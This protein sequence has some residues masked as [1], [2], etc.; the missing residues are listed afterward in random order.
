MANG[1]G[2]GRDLK[3]ARVFLVDQNSFFRHGLRSAL[4]RRQ[5]VEVV[6]DAAVEEGVYEIIRSLLPEVVLLGLGSSVIPG[7]QLTRK[8]IQS[9]PGTS[10]V[11]VTSRPDDDELL[12][13][14]A[15][16]AAAYSSKDIEADDLARIIV[17]VAGGELPVIE[18]LEDNPQLLARTIGHFQDLLLRGRVAGIVNSPITDREMEVLTLVACGYGNKQ[19][20]SAFGISEQTIKNHMA[21]ILR[22][23]GACDRTHAVVMAMQYGWITTNSNGKEP[24]LMAH[25]VGKS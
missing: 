7:M 25:G 10:V 21:A 6:G 15:A 24:E 18:N 5:D 14:I 2:S 22:K 11:A 3:T 17:A 16:G 19:I 20:A 23:M 4:A 8:I 12:Q 9:L 1:N 13:L